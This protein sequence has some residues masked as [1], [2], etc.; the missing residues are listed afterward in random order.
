MTVDQLVAQ[1]QELVAHGLSGDTPVVVW[2]I[3]TQEFGPVTAICY[4][5]DKVELT[6]ELDE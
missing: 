4:G 3:E 2:D 5:P 1:L 6:S